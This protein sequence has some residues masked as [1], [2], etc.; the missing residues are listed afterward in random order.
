MMATIDAMPQGARLQYVS[1][2]CVRELTPVVA[3][4]GGLWAVRIL[5][6][7]SGFKHRKIDVRAD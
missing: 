5:S 3:V 4:C 2:G 7:V 6:T 1:A